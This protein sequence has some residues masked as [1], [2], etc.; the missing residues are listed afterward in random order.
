MAYPC[1]VIQSHIWTKVVVSPERRVSFRLCFHLSTHTEIRPRTI[2]NS[3]IFV[4]CSVSRRIS[5]LRGDNVH[6]LSVSSLRHFQTFLLHV[7]VAIT[8]S[9]ILSTFDIF[10]SC[11]PLATVGGSVCI[12]EDTRM[13]KPIKVLDLFVDWIHIILR[14]SSSKNGGHP[15]HQ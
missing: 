1:T 15:R 12:M 5:D 13:W 7:F 4:L 2:P 3:T 11:L 14:L 6:I 9:W 8:A 10:T